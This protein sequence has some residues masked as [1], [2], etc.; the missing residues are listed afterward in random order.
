MPTEPIN[1]C[2]HI[3]ANTELS[4]PIPKHID[5]V[6]EAHTHTHTHTHTQSDT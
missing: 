4:E 2:L 3:H 6:K 1:L 5:I